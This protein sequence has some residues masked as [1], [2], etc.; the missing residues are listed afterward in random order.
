MI[1]PKFLIHAQQENQGKF[2]QVVMYNMRNKQEVKIKLCNQ[3]KRNKLD[4]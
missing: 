3:D 2:I 1:Y 4:F